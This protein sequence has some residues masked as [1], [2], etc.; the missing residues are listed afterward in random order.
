MNSRKIRILVVSSIVVVVLL[1]IGGIFWVQK[2]NSSRPLSSDN[3]P[4]EPNSNPPPLK[5]P[6][7]SDNKDSNDQTKDKNNKDKT[8]IKIQWGGDCLTNRDY[9]SYFDPDKLN[10]RNARPEE[11]YYYIRKNHPTLAGKRLDQKGLV[12][13]L[14]FDEG[15]VVKRKVEANLDKNNLQFGGT[16]LE[17]CFSLTPNI[18]WEDWPGGFENRKTEQVEFVNSV[19]RDGNAIF[20]HGDP[21]KDTK[22]IIDV[23]NPVIQKLREKNNLIIGK[24]YLLTFSQENEYNKYSN[25]SDFYYFD[26]K[27]KS[28]DIHS[29]VAGE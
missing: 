10:D 15:K 18:P 5:N 17:S 24:K 6:P 8:E 13:T 11:T 28:I 29:A 4:N 3:T 12:L 14:S 19:L 27:N 7:P 23:A 20:K 26:A 9:W 21:R 22:F 16:F 1:A 2:K 25:N